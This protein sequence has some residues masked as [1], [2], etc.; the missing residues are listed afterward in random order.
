MTN[1]EMD[2]IYDVA[3]D[4]M[5]NGRFENL[6]LRL[7]ELRVE[8]ASLDRLLTWLIATLPAKSKLPSRKN[9]IHAVRRHA[10]S[11][12]EYHDLLAGLT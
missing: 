11:D 3:D 12:V 8:T 2:R 9:L 1:Q 10:K 7:K 5:R 4:L 6:D